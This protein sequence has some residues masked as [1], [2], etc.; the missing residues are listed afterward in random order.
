MTQTWNDSHATA[1]FWSRNQNTARGEGRVCDLHWLSLWDGIW[2]LLSLN[3]C[4][5]CGGG[6]W[7]PSS[8]LSWLVE[9]SL[10]LRMISA[11]P[12]CPRVLGGLWANAACRFNRNP[13]CPQK[14]LKWWGRRGGRMTF[15]RPVTWQALILFLLLGSYRGFSTLKAIPIVLFLEHWV[16]EM[17]SAY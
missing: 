6:V 14:E 7:S 17:E 13:F 8:Q 5:L 9:A 4:L 16:T 12:L 2:S 15:N 10:R 1:N 11:R 3:H